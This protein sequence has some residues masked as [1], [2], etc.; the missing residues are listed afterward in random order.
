MSIIVVTELSCDGA[1]CNE[2]S[3]YIIRN[4]SAIP[5]ARR[6]ARKASWITTSKGDFCPRCAKLNINMEIPDA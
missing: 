6:V 1:G 5:A 3:P 2:R 4:R